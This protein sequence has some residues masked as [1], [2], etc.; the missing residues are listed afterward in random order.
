MNQNVLYFREALSHSDAGGSIEE[1]KTLIVSFFR[2]DGCYSTEYIKYESVEQIAAIICTN[3]Y[4]KLFCNSSDYAVFCTEGK[5]LD[6][7][8]SG[9]EERFIAEL[10]EAVETANPE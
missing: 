7:C 3:D 2:P 1:G 6:S 9:L 10:M 8:V 4:D 5:R